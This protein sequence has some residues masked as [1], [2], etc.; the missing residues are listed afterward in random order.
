MRSLRAIPALVV[1]LVACQWVAAVEVSPEET[2]EARRWVSAKFEGKPQARP[3]LGYLLPKIKSGALERNARQK[4]P[5]KIATES[6]ATGI[7]CPSKGTIQV[8]LP[9]PGKRFTAAVGVDSNDI[10]YYSSLGRSDVTVAVEVKGKQV[11]KTPA[12]H[13]GMAAI[14]VDVDLAGTTD[15]T[16][17]VAGKDAAIDWDQVD[18]ANAKAT[19]GDG[20]ELGLETLPTAPLSGNYTADPIFSFVFDGKKSGD[21]LKGWT[22]QRSSREIDSNQTEHTQTYHDPKTGLELRVVGI[23]YHD[24]PT[25]E[26]TLY[27]K[28][29]GKAD[30]PILEK[31]EAL[32]TKLER[33]GNGEFVLHHNKGAP[34]T[35]NDYEPYETPLEKNSDHALRAK[36]G[37]PSNGDLP[38]FNLAWP[39]EGAIIVVGWPGQWAGQLTRDGANG[40]QIRVGQELTHFKL[41][42]GEE[43]RTPRIVMTFWKGEWRR[44]QNMWRR[45]MMAHN[46]PHPG[47]QLPP[48]QMAGN[49]SREYVEMTEATDR[50]ENMFIDRYVEEKL[51]P[52]YFWM[53][54]G[55]YPNNGSWVNT[56]TWEVD[57]KRFPKGLR[58]VSDNAHAKGVKI[59]VWFEPER[60]TKGSWLYE[61]H[62]E[63]LLTPTPNPGDQLYD[64]EWKLFN[65]GD[66]LAL[67][68]MTDHVDK[69]INEQGIDLYRQD[70]N[71]DPLNYWRAHDAADRQGITEIRYVTGYLAYWDELR[72]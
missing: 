12:M 38:Y 16:L 33:S 31:I 56:G 69:L 7:H 59:I 65:F 24:F 35:A 2:A 66:P 55:W 45:W 44:S 67:Q 21:L 15:F 40:V 22:L 53:D 52:D 1:V 39:D 5:L 51:N 41:L 34:A 70:F 42:P 43:V 58:A 26:W 6:F 36:G 9:A 17:L 63:W 61:N 8:H 57:T 19:L 48:P 68:W 18:F 32:D 46:M 72:R 3:D 54:A 25:V 20:R 50:D 29:T 11:F 27:F 14:P 30:S 49:T 13:E 64:N 47:G 4:H 28:N 71:M 62:P 60:V 23:E 10:S 37:R